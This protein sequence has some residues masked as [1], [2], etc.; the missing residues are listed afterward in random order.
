M[1][2]ATG[3]YPRP[4]IHRAVGTPAR[5]MASSWR[6]PLDSVERRLVAL[7]GL[8]SIG[9]LAG[10]LFMVTHPLTT[11]PLK[12]LDGTWF[13]TW[14]WPGIALFCFV[15]VGP[16]M[17]VLATLQRRTWASV[18][19]FGVGIGLIGWILLEAAWIVVSPPLQLTFGLIGVWITVLAV[20][21]RRRE[22]RRSFNDQ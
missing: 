2:G 21:E 1:K 3:S 11:M 15:G 18:G 20:E 17:A 13:H 8:V 16:A 12:Y 7:E 14:R 22:S 5:G 6:R 10:G 19:H 9:A 4:V